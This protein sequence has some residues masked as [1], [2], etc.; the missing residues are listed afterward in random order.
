M[1]LS[2]LCYCEGNT[3]PQLF[4]LTVEPGL[5]DA[6][7]QIAAEENL[8]VFSLGRD[9]LS[10]VSKFISL[11]TNQDFIFPDFG[12]FFRLRDQLNKIAPQK[13]FQNLSELFREL[14]FYQEECE[15]LSEGDRSSGY[16]SLFIGN[17]RPSQ[18][19]FS[20]DG[21]GR[22]DYYVSSGADDAYCLQLPNPD[23]VFSP[24]FYPSGELRSFSDI[25]KPAASRNCTDGAHKIRGL[26]RDWFRLVRE[27]AAQSVLMRADSPETVLEKFE[28][29][30]NASLMD[31]LICI[32]EE[33]LLESFLQ[34]RALYSPRFQ[35]VAN[36]PQS[37][38]SSV[39]CFQNDPDLNRLMKFD[40]YVAA[41]ILR[42]GEFQAFFEEIRAFGERCFILCVDPAVLLEQGVRLFS[43]TEAGFCIAPPT[44]SLEEAKCIREKDFP[45]GA[46]IPRRIT[47]EQILRIVFAE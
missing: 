14:H 29:F 26:A 18:I 12:H 2:F 37:F 19:P 9:F 30:K 32:I 31:C 36:L 47:E 44:F 41:T 33:E 4:C 5:G 28:E 35:T 38:I 16:S 15:R 7:G 13:E 39:L 24:E 6:E 46:L 8:T 20:I 42:K 10:E 21:K 40:D 17:R 11:L 22:V 23:A 43:R 45:S 27:Q 34:H 1:S 25:R 3:S